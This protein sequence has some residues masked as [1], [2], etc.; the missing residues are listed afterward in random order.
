M[1]RVL[2][3]VA[4]P[5][6]TIAAFA[7]LGAAVIGSYVSASVP[8]W[9]VALALGL[10]A[11]N[12]AAALFAKPS[13]RRGGLG[14]FHVA[15]LGCLLL[16]A[17]GRLAHFSGR[18]AIADGQAFEP[19]M[20]ETVSRGAWHGEAYRDLKF[21]QG[22][23]TV[24]YAPGVRREH[25]RS[26]V[27]VGDGAGSTPFTVGDDQPLVL[28]G[29]RFYTTSNKGYAPILTWIGADRQPM[30]GAVMLPSYPLNDWQQEHRWT[31]PDGVEWRFWLR[32]SRPV[33]ESKAW[34]LDPRRTDAVL[35]AERAGARFELRPGDEA[36]GGFGVLRYEWLAGWMGYKV[37]YDPTL[38]P[39]LAL[40]VVGVLGM[41]WHL[42]TT[43]GRRRRGPVASGAAAPGRSAFTAQR[44]AR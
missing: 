11:V 32:Q 13:L 43:P 20:I 12:L 22:P 2:A 39:L 28:D 37:F 17:Y 7:A 38:A 34:T 4:S 25:T 18:L 5:R 36:R 1:T 44:A 41:A 31:A 3:V 26:Q 15:L 8:A 35:I 27:V 9:T 19:P 33:D 16:V 24:S 30:S 40:S 6:L 10:L 21:M 29:Y 14:V 23:F 42:V